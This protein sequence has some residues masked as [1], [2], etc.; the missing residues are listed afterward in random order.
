MNGR[1][2]ERVTE[3]SQ[4]SE[5]NCSYR[6]HVE[7]NSTCRAGLSWIQGSLTM[8]QPLGRWCSPRTG[9][10]LDKWSC[11]ALPGP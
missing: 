7:L 10:A 3:G 11:S 8:E 6:Y 4:T 9:I 5:G 2:Q 1:V